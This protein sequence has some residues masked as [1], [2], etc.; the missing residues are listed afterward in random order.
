MDV[1]NEDSQVPLYDGKIIAKVTRLSWDASPPA[2]P[3]AAANGAGGRPAAPAPA[4]A[5]APSRPPPQQPVKA[6]QP[7]AL[8]F[9]DAPP[10]RAPAP[11]APAVQ[12]ADILG[13]GFGGAPAAKA[14]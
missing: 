4:P 11:A 12:E 8:L 7:D 5:A 13:T 6:S 3:A 10:S 9:D 1:T 14:K 2:G